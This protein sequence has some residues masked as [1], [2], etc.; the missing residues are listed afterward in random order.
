[1][2][3]PMPRKLGEVPLASPSRLLRQLTTKTYL[4]CA[5][6]TKRTA[7]LTAIESIGHSKKL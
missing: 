4:H 3:G 6:R 7:K 1:M 5:L 2:L